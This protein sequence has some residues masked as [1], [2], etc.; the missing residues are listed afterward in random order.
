MMLL[1]FQ[2]SNGNT[3][4]VVAHRGGNLWEEKQS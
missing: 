2:S 1:L 3:Q 4:I